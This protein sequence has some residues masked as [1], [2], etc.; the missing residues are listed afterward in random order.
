M[1]KICYVLSYKQVP[2]KLKNF[3]KSLVLHDL[4]V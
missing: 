1:P 4:N 2:Q 3:A